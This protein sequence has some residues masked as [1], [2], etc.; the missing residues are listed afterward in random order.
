MSLFADDLNGPAAEEQHPACESTCHAALH[1]CSSESKTF[2][3]VLKDQIPE[4][5]F[6]DILIR[7]A[8]G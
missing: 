1:G 7:N 5:V 2:H 4:P 3:V 6:V 8:D